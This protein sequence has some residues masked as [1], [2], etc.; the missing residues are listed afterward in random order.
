[1]VVFGLVGTIAFNAPRSLYSAQE[2][3]MIPFPAIHALRDTSIHVGFSNGHGISADIEA[4][5]D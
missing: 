5:V 1:M 4:P 3:C 2:S